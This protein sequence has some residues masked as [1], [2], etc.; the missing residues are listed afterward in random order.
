MYGRS[1]S[2]HVS[3]RKSYSPHRSEKNGS[4]PAIRFRGNEV[5]G[6]STDNQLFSPKAHQK[7]TLIEKIQQN[8]GEEKP[9]SDTKLFLALEALE[10]SFQ[11]INQ[12]KKETIEVSM[13]YFSR[14][15]DHL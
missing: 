3:N 9:G 12:Y 8:L 2:N 5:R 11:E 6:S 14:N 7:L 4:I 13:K 10:K 15:C 1:H